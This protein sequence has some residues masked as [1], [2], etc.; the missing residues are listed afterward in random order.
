MSKQ[1]KDYPAQECPVCESFQSEVFSK[2]KRKGYVHD[3]EAVR[4]KV[5]GH[6]GVI[7]VEDSEC[8]DIEWFQ[9]EKQRDIKEENS[10]KPIK[11]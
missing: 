8:A 11:S 9:C 6:E 4:C 5:C 7:V 1:W 10:G 2:S 3:G